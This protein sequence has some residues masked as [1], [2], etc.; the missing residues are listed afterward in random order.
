[1]G[2]PCVLGERGVESIVEL[3][4]N[5]REREEFKG[6]VAS[7]RADIERLRNLAP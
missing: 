7:V 5:D 3:D 2:V 4:L 6:S 1:M